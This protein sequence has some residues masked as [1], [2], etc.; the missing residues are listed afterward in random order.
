M[1]ANRGL[2]MSSVAVSHLRQRAEHYRTLAEKESD[3]KKQSEYCEIAGILDREAD[4]VG[5][6]EAE[7]QYPQ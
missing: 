3:P 7:G 5:E 4:V 1:H 2:T 6:E